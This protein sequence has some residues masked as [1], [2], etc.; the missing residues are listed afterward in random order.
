MTIEYIIREQ[1]GRLVLIFA[2]WSTDAAMFTGLNVP[3][4]DIAVVSDYRDVS[5]FDTSGLSEYREIVVMAWSMGVWAADKTLP[6][7]DLP[8]T[9]TI[10]V[11]GTTTPVD[12]RCGIPVAIFNVT[13]ESL[14]ERSLVKFRRRVC[15]SAAAYAEFAV[16]F[17]SRPVADLADELRAI[18]SSQSQAAPRLR[19]DRA[20]I[21]TADAI[22]P[23]ANQLAAWPA[24]T[25]ITTIDSP[26]LPDF[27]A[28]LD[29]FVIDKT[30]VSRR[31]SRGMATYDSE[32][33]IQHLIAGHL[34][35]LWQ[36]HLKSV[37]PAE[38][39]IEIGY[40][41]GALT[42]LYTHRLRPADLRLWD[43]IDS[44]TGLPGR[45][46]TCDAEIAIGEIPP[47]S[48]DTI[49]SSSTIQW[50]NSTPAFLSRA[51]SALRPGGLLAV[52]TFGP[53]T[54][55]ELVAAGA[56]PVP[57][58][59]TGV[60][61]ASVP[62]SMEIL[63]LHEGILTRIMNSAL[64]VMRHLQATGVNARHDKVSLVS[65]LRHYPLRTDGRA[66]LTYN[67]IYLLLQK[68]NG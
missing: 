14:T 34:W 24:R 19:W 11:N 25:D 46:E 60:L 59:S 15:G 51:A 36:K 41:T 44:Q 4:Y 55:R 43:I 37:R 62:E 16:R 57:Y 10:A 67:P 49:A 33:S 58:P 38:S 29:R 1:R 48:V 66:P 8:I 68:K 7:Q 39:L 42:R 3:G 53:H 22:F 6:G 27:Q 32:A 9:L 52:S 18:A 23:P 17:V 64:D 65:L 26:H 61:R 50:F 28:I 40:G 63:E 35:D 2:G 5:A 12:D 13:T 30:L 54:C 56:T 45:I 47:E 20:V 31:F 21:G